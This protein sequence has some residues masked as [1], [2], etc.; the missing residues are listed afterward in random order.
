MYQADDGMFCPLLAGADRRGSGMAG[1]AYRGPHEA[2]YLKLDCSKLKNTF[3]WQP[4]WKVETA[5]LRTAQWYAAYQRG[6]DMQAYTLAQICDFLG[7]D[8]NELKTE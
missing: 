2:N 7:Q 5:V 4:R 3:G 8:G 6:D 1:G